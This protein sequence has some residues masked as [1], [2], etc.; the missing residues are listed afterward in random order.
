[1]FYCEVEEIIAEMLKKGQSAL[2][3]YFLKL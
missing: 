3:W 1:V 2:K